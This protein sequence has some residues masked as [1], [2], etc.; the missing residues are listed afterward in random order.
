MEIMLNKK[1][2]K[3]KK[4][5]RNIRT[6]INKNLN[7]TRSRT[8]MMKMKDM[9]SKNSRTMAVMKMKAPV[10]KPPLTY[11]TVDSRCS[12]KLV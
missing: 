1:M 10:A 7:R 6:K 2:M 11:A 12:I 8:V 4:N 5:I 3:K 9:K